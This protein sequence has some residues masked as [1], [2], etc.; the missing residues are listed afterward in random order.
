MRVVD[1]LP[2]NNH[3]IQGHSG[4][5][6]SKDGIRQDHYLVIV[7]CSV[8]MVRSM[9]EGISMVASTRYVLK[10]IIEIF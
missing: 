3:F 4:Q 6:V 2:Q 5:D 9:G 1:F 7:S 8:V 10:L